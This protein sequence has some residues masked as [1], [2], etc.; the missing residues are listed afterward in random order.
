MSREAV[1]LALSELWLDVEA[2]AD[3]RQHIVQ[4][5]R[6]SGLAAD[7]LEQIFYY[8]VAPVVWLNGWATAGVWA[9]FDQQWLF[10]ACRRNQARGRWHRGKCRLLRW[11]MTNLCI[12]EWR[13]IRAVL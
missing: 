6:A 2:D 1:W 5:L 9:G 13:Q 8:E 11:P 7:E 12:E 10:A 4:V 3:S